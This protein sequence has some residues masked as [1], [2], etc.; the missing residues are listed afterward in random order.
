MGPARQRDAAPVAE[1][2]DGPA[3]NTLFSFLTQIA[4]AAFTAALTLY[5]VRALGP[6]EFGVFSLAVGVGAFLYLPS[7]F[8]ISASAS[9]FV[10]ER[11]GDD[12]A[13]AALLSDSLRLKLAISGIV[14]AALIV[15]AGPIAAA[16]SV[17]SLAWPVR[18]MAIAVLGQS[19][20]AFYRYVYLAMHEGSLGFRIVFGESAVET[21]ASI[22]FVV[23]AG[24][25]AAAS[26]G[27]ATGYAA[28]ALLALALTL[29]RFGRT[30]ILGGHG[31]ASARRKLARYAAALFV[32]DA[33]YSASV[34]VSP[35]LIGGFLGPRAVGL[36]QAPMRLI[37]L[38]QYPG[39]AVG[40]GVA[41]SMARREGQGPNVR[42][43]TA[44]LR[45]LIVF[46]A[47]VLAPVLVWGGPIVDLLLGPKYGRSA[48]LLKQLTPYIYMSGL[49]SLVVF[50]VNFLGVARWRVPIA[51]ADLVV[52][53]AATAALLSAF[54]LSG[55]A[56]ASDIVPLFYV[57]AHLWIIKRTIDL[58]LRPFFV[59]AG[60]SLVAAVAMAPV[61]LAF[62]TSHLT[63]LDWVG[64]GV[65][66][67][68]AFAGTLLLTREVTVDDL[69][70]L[71]G[72]LASLRRPR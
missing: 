33:A 60:R 41:P 2:T 4:T 18:W 16:Y 54:G 21:G 72:A 30:A 19:L 25:A 8:G 48:T 57:P 32:I 6:R 51:V 58:P 24:G 20:V 17:P 34:A 52:N 49:N 50:A 44:T 37:V 42:L 28:G 36:Y 10:A 69:R 23:A 61:L 62:G 43:F 63:P 40:T 9:R 13:I 11:R 22:A 27:R 35:L 71:P 26:A 65:L 15:A 46:Q 45:Y 7:D 29:R 59:A 14:S 55:A 38:I 66:G 1:S 70:R 3:R 5:L 68:A 31:L 39:V 12:S 67:L 56:W 53:A 64:G 47:V